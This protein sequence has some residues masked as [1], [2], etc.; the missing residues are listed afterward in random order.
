[1]A[2]SRITIPERTS[3]IYALENRS[4]QLRESRSD[5]K[6]KLSS[7]SLE[8]SPI[9]YR[10]L[11][12]AD[13][14]NEVEEQKLQKAWLDVEQSER[15]VTDSK[16]CIAHR[17]T[18]QRIISLGDEMWRHKQA[19]REDEEQSGKAP[20]LGP[21]ST[22]A[23]IFTLLT[24][25]K[26]PNTSS[27]RSSTVQSEMQRSVLQV[28]EP[29]K[30]AP[31]GK[32]WCPIAR[33][34]FDEEMM[35]TAHIVPKALSAGLVEYIFGAGTG[36]RV[37]TSDNCLI[38]HISTE[39][40]FDN[41]NFV[42]V[43]ANPAESPIK[44][45]KVKLAN[46]AAKNSDV[47]RRILGDCDG[48]ELVF[49]N[50]NRPAARFLYYHFVV[51]LLRNKKDRQP[52]WER[53][54]VDLPTGK[55]FATPGRYLR[56]SM[57]VTLAKSV[58]DLNAE[59]EAKLLGTPGQE[60]FVDKERLGEAEEAEIGRRVLVAHE[61]GDDDDDDSDDEGEDAGEEEEEGEEE[62]EEEDEE[63]ED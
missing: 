42:I 30:G 6:R 28:Y 5:L 52:G 8:S 43:P 12:I 37:N 13:L 32:F 51:T 15:K 59:E 20:R 1:M 35:V 34:Y 55:P 7:T 9:L 19:L 44:T 62:D 53:F 48:E 50:E 17:N 26:D 33:D 22:G 58:G 60:T 21:D 45:W 24:L 57:L 63:R 39:R 10:K 3:S 40:G 49:K 25:Y 16:Y 29:S 27:K 4:L 11:K 46:L 54:C 14:E 31:Q 18:N 41:G 38:L 61:G 2:S 47:G 56:Q 36:S 23:F